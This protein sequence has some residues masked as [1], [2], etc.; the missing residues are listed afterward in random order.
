[1]V[2]LIEENLKMEKFMEKVNILFI[3]QKLFIKVNFI[4]EFHQAIL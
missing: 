4:M 3:K 1:M 2:I